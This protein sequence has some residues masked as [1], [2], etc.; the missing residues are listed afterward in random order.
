MENA[1]HVDALVDANV[2]HALAI[3]DA[4]NLAAQSGANLVV[5]DAGVRHI[6]IKKRR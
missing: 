2:L 3:A 1:A 6:K 4:L 5:T